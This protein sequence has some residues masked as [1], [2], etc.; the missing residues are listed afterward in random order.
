MV[1]K[2]RRTRKCFAVER[3]LHTKLCH[4]SF[5][6]IYSLERLLATITCK[7][8]AN[9]FKSGDSEQWTIH[10]LWPNYNKGGYP[11]RSLCDAIAS[12]H[13]VTQEAT[14]NMWQAAQL[15]AQFAPQ[16]ISEAILGD[17]HARQCI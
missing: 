11:V 3:L 16:N 9:A 15:A 8:N 6:I 14:L 7:V 2:S 4:A 1:S 12:A 13:N 10:G 17:L 5:R